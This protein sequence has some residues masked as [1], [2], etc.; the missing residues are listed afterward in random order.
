MFLIPAISQVSPP[1]IVPKKDMRLIYHLYY[2]HANVSIN[3]FIDQT[4]CSV[5]YSYKD[6]GAELKTQVGM[7]AKTTTKR[8]KN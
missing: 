8:G 5:Q 7:G 6:Q 4:S 1:G 2:E 3:D